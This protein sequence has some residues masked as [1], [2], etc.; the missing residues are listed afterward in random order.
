[1]KER[2]RIIVVV[3]IVLVLMLGVAF[4]LF[5]QGFYSFGSPSVHLEKVDFDISQE[6]Q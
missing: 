2:K 5:S 3:T 4:F 6:V 1:M